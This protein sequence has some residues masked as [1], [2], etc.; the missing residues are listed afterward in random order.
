MFT[1]KENKTAAEAFQAVLEKV[2]GSR[3]DMVDYCYNE[4]DLIVPLAD[5]DFLTI[6][7][8]R[9]EK[10][11]CFGYGFCGVSTREDE[12]NAR[13]MACKARTDEGYFL[14]ENL[15]DIDRVLSLLQDDG[16]TVYKFTQYSGNGG[17]NYK[18]YRIAD[19][20]ETPENNVHLRSLP[21]LSVM[22]RE[23]RK[24]LFCAY[25]EERERFC[26]RLSAY[27][28]RYGLSKVRA[29]SYLSD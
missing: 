8:P 13:G 2:W 6:D 12:E 29:W 24:T 5:G 10:S 11:F 21:G 7:K 17:T 23:E 3:G 19:A 28:K 20:W 9:I 22:T 16:K 18:A 25:S 27:L 15:K 1:L 4:A 14:R 26:K